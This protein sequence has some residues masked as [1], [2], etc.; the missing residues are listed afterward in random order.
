MEKGSRDYLGQ[1]LAVIFGGRN[2]LT[3]EGPFL[4]LLVKF[5]EN[6]DSHSH[7][8]VIGYSFR[9]E[10]I[11]QC[12]VRWLGT[13]VSRSITIVDQVG[14][15]TADNLFCR[16]RARDLGQRLTFEPTGVERAIAAHFG[17]RC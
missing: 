5:K 2:K 9:D 6:L 14:K 8:L 15:S 13:D 11:N 10:H 16:I 12:I 17:N 7:L 4:D 3:A 1:R